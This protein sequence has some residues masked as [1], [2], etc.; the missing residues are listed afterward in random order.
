MGL[1]VKTVFELEGI[2]SIKLKWWWKM[3]K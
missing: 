2:Q 1:Q 3:W